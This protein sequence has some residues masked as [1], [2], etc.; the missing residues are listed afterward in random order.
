RR[1]LPQRRGG[2][3]LE[4][5]VSGSAAA[6]ARPSMLRRRPPPRLQH[7]PRICRNRC[8]VPPEAGEIP[9]SASD[10]R[11]TPNLNCRDR[12]IRDGRR[13]LNTVLRTYPTL[14]KEKVTLAAHT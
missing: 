13:R 1:T 3:L 14:A 5:W 9:A 8:S 4:T 6:H 7:P 2:G 11:R 12:R 10:F